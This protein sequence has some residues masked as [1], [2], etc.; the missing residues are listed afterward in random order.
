M[1]KYARPSFLYIKAMGVGT[2]A[3]SWLN[4]II[5]DESNVSIAL[6]I[7]GGLFYWRDMLKK[8]YT[9]CEDILMNS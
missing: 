2:L 4:T 9:A 6:A 3:G 8:P 1:E 5:N 7:S